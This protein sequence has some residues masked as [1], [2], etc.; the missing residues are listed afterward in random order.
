MASVV[1]YYLLFHAWI[2]PRICRCA[3]P[4]VLL[5]EVADP[6]VAQR[7]T[8]TITQGTKVFGDVFAFDRPN[9]LRDAVLK[10]NLTDLRC[11]KKITINKI[12]KRFK[13]LG[14]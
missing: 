2:A 12:M 13:L 11:T 1:N 9:A 6:A 3:S 10:T 7:L 5:I 4:S 8:V 14:A